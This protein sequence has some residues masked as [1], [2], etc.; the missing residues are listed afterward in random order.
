MD[1]Y[2]NLE[3]YA[4]KLENLLKKYERIII[5]NQG[6]ID[7]LQDKVY[8]YLKDALEKETEAEGLY[9]KLVDYEN[10]INNILV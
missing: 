5:D 9:L 1:N 4:R 3:H 6:M 10:T 8:E 7:D 2:K